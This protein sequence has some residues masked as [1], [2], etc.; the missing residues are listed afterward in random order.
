MGANAIFQGLLIRNDQGAHELVQ[1][2]CRRGFPW[3]NGD[4]FGLRFVIH[5]GLGFYGS[6]LANPFKGCGG[7]AALSLGSRRLGLGSHRHF[8]G[9]GHDLEAPLR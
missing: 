3:L 7:A 9:A 8:C 5:N 1:H 4:W 6:V 2:E